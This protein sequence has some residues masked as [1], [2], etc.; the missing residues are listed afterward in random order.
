MF[1]F[2]LIF[3]KLSAQNVDQVIRIA[4]SLYKNQNYSLA[5]NEYK[6][7]CFFSN[8]NKKDILNS[9]ISDCYINLGEYPSAKA[10]CDSA[11]YYSVTDSLKSD[12]EF[13]KIYCYLLERNFG[14][15]LLKLDE[16]KTDSNSNLTLKKEF[17]KGVSYYG[18]EKFNE[19]F[20]SFL[21]AISPSDSLKKTTLQKLFETQKQLYTPN[22]P[23]VT[24][25]SV[26]LPGAGQV[27]TGNYL[28]GLNSF[29]LL[30]GL[31]MAGVNI[32]PLYPFLIPV[33]SRYYIGGV[34]R[35]NHFAHEKQ[36]LNQYHFIRDVLALFP[37]NEYLI[38]AFE[39][40]PLSTNFH[41]H[42]FDS[43]SEIHLLLSASFLG[44]KKLL[45][46]Q[47]VDACVFNP[48]CSVYMMETI[49]KNGAIKGF[50][51][52]V[53]RLLRCHMLADKHNYLFDNFTQKYIDEP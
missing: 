45:S 49:R 38:S 2:A 16:I 52:G 40:K 33:F 13:K 23:L 7:A 10:Y 31:V 39:I 41:Q 34:I 27:Y 24:T 3:S 44:Y 29:V 11:I 47:D 46:S 20:Q 12:Y 1:I 42:T 4:D 48:T 14:Y 43:D 18:I 15:A 19:A 21:N 30:T 25:M 51:D 37:E 9:R 5:L 35:A 8:E 17:L 32:P 6:R 36:K 22:L 26:L 28:S 53:D 50:I